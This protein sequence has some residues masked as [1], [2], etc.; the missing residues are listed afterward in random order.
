MSTCLHAYLAHGPGAFTRPASLS[1]S[2]SPFGG[3]T[4]RVVD[5]LQSLIVVEFVSLLISHSCSLPLCFSIITVIIN[6]SNIFQSYE[7]NSRNNWTPGENTDSC[8]GKRKAQNGE[9]RVWGVHFLGWLMAWFL[10][11]GRSSFEG[12]GVFSWKAFTAL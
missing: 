12:A 8:T 4:Q 3:P 10:V 2:L 5:R 7:H 1:L 11:T 6:H 9:R